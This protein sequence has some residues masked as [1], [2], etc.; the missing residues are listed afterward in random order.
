MA[1]ETDRRPKVSGR[2]K[3][4]CQ[5]GCAIVKGTF[6]TDFH[7]RV[8]PLAISHGAADW[9]VFFVDP[10]MDIR[11]VRPVDGV[12]IVWTGGRH[13]DQP[14]HRAERHIVTGARMAFLGLKLM[15]MG[16]DPGVPKEVHRGPSRAMRDAK[17]VKRVRDIVRTIH[18]A[19]K[20]PLFI[21][22]RGAGH[23]ERVMTPASVLQHVHHRAEIAV[24]E[25]VEET[26]DRI[27]PAHHRPGRSAVDRQL[28]ARVQR[29]MAK[30]R[31]I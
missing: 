13:T 24:V 3:V 14:V 27:G 1:L 7:R 25:L 22:A 12:K 20:A 5:R 6:L 9:G 26:R 30:G 11:W 23:A 21:A 4:F 15:R 18:M 19:R 10:D 29:V 8:L 28:K 31:E 17:R 2:G 16:I